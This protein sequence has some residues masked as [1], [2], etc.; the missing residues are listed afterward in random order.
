MR[1]WYVGTGVQIPPADL[2]CGE[3]DP[4]FVPVAFLWLVK[5]LLALAKLQPNRLRKARS[6][7]LRTHLTLAARQNKN[8]TS[9]LL[10]KFQRISGFVL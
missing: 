2:G 8:L 3:R 4:F 9:N 6:F 7:F 10:K 5:V 1:I